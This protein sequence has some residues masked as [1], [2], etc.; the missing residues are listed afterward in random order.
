[1]APKLKEWKIIALAPAVEDYP[2]E[3]ECKGREV[4]SAKLWYTPYEDIHEPEKLGILVYFKQYDASEEDDFYLPVANKMV[5]LILGEKSGRLDVIHLQ[6]D[7]LPKNPD[8]SILPFET[9]PEYIYVRNSL[10]A[11]N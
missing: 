1:M 2:I 11:M 4:S 9:L 3:F 7:R 10:V 6:V 8:A 5:D